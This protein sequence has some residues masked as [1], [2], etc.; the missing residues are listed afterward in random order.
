MTS[1]SWKAG[2]SILITLVLVVAMGDRIATHDPAAQFSDFVFAPPMIPH[3]V[4]TTGEWRLPF[5]YPAR[6][7]NRLARRYSI[8]RHNPR[9]LRWFHDGRLVSAEGIPWFPLGTDAIGR[10]VFARLVVGARLSLG[11]A[12]VGVMGAL[13]VGAGIGGVAGH[14][15]GTLDRVLMRMSDFIVSLP[16]IY[17]VLTVRAALPLVLTTTQVFWTM[18]AALAAVGWP[19]AARGVRAIVSGERGREYAEA[20]LAA[21]A[22]RTRLLLRHLLPASFGFLG[23]QAT[24]LVPA[25]ILA[26]AT[27]SYL[28]LGFA[29]ASPSWGVMLQE[30]AGGRALLEAPWLL[31]PAAAIAI[32]VFA[33]NLLA[34]SQTSPTRGRPLSISA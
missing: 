7:E 22:G 20:A 12:V 14:A 24:L 28:G 8:D 32:T 30:A 27:L 25:F 4:D 13:L 16:A 29:Q 33:I 15:G 6:L 18:T 1:S 17:I 31:A 21:G 2:A 11:V 19:L 9:P 5:I 26:E 10:D 23:V 34:I 3:V